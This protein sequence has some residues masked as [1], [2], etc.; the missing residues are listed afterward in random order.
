LD[1]TRYFLPPLTPL[2]GKKKFLLMGMDNPAGG[3]AQI[4]T[5]QRLITTAES[6]C[7]AGSMCACVMDECRE[8][9][10]AP[11]SGGFEGNALPAVKRLIEKKASNAPLL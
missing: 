7:H 9:N 10:Q 4:I 11:N 2:K 3:T 6:T 1:I 5:K 8:R